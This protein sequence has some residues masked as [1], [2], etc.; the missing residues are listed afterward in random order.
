MPEE[1]TPR[2]LA[3]MDEDEARTTLT[4]AQFERW[5]QLQDLFDQ[6]AETEAEW[7]AEEETVREVTV[8][9]D[10]EQLG[11]QVDIYGN[12]LLVRADPES[13]GLQDALETLEADFGDIEVEDPDADGEA[14]FGDVDTDR[15]DDLADHLLGMLD[16][17]IVRWDGTRWDGLPRAQRETIL[18]DARVS[19]GVDGLMLAWARIAAEIR[20]DR[21]GTVSQLESFRGEAGRGDN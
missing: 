12:D 21:E 2:E 11:T 10:M 16:E 18:A 8:S 15:L 20:A 17:V 19:W 9:A 1:Y 14:A 4:V 5:E 6:Q 3:A 7:E 13:Q